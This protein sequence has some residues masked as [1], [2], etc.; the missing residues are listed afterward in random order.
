MPTTTR[1]RASKLFEELTKSFIPGEP[2]SDTET[3]PDY[4]YH[5]TSL[6]NAH[7]IVDSGIKPHRP[8][9]GTDQNAWPDGATERRSYFTDKAHVAWHFAPTDGKAVLLRT[10]KDSAKFHTEHG[11]GDF[12]VREPVPPDTMEIMDHK[13]SWHP[14]KSAL[15]GE[16]H[17]AIE[18]G[19]KLQKS[20]TA[21]FQPTAPH[22]SKP[23]A[24]RRPIPYDPI[25][26]KNMF[27]APFKF[28]PHKLGDLWQL[29][30]QDKYPAQKVKKIGVQASVA[31]ERQ[32]VGAPITPEG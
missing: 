7:D 3:H 6:E 10:H 25:A 27:A 31:A 29:H 17:T 16:K 4:R 13:G 30:L 23:R 24:P 9:H 26:G 21:P 19:A 11:T 15:W 18:G 20:S 1:V 14:L 28:K 2:K 12:F 8:W 22:P 5:A 32:P